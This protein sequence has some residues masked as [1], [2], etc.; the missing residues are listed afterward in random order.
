M[1]NQEWRDV[2]L[3]I[4]LALLA[5]PLM[6]LQGSAEIKLPQVID[7]HMVLQRGRAA[8]V[9]GTAV[10]GEQVTVTFRDQKKITIADP[11]GKWRVGLDALKAGGPDDLVIT[12]SKSKARTLEDV[13]VGDVW[14][15]SGQ[16]NMQ[17]GIAEAVHADPVLAALASNTYSRIRL[18]S[19]DTRGWNWQRKFTPP[20]PDKI[21]ETSAPG[22][23]VATSEALPHFSALL[24]SFGAVLQKEIDVPIG[25]I[26]GSLGATPSGAWVPR[27]AYAA[28]DKIK[29]AI[30]RYEKE[31]YP[32]IMA[33]ERRQ[34]Q[35]RCDEAKQAG[36]EPPPEPWQ[37][38]RLK[39]GAYVKHPKFS[40]AHV[41]YELRI[42]PIMPFAIRGVLWDQGESQVDFVGVDQ[43]TLMG[44][45]IAGWRKDWG[46]DFPFLYMQKPSGPGCAWDYA[47][48]VTCKAVPF[49]PL[50]ETVPPSRDGLF[51]E[52]FI[53]LM[54]YPDTHM[55]PCSDL[56]PGNHP[57]NKSGYGIR[58][59]RVA[60]SVAYGHKGTI[61]GPRFESYAIAGGNVRVA[62]SDVGEGLAWK[63]GEKLQGFALAGADEVFH[64]A[65][66]VID[67]NTVVV[68]CAEVKK[69]VAVRY[70][71]GATYEW[72]NLF[73]KDGLPA[74]PFRTDDW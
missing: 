19:T 5:L 36:R 59:A 16:S 66:A 6:P 57:L 72:A 46:Q 47:D 37:W 34:W 15:G 43:Y 74:I 71:W 42:K 30:A 39:P 61:Y 38:G 7:N 2:P 24:F 28:S 62:F 69:P 35:A 44:V 58:S 9:W 65:D 32:G 73:N 11:D 45:L 14:V 21:L 60:L 54:D 55:V 52:A 51:A 20:P 56:G 4:T 17:L 10:P 26:E 25:L 53:R 18:L 49:A 27:D 68:S 50:P 41:H 8:P 70:G 22:W 29:A 64:W 63:H 12:G 13:L 48:P 40:G 31:V 67:K 23:H 3:A 1:A 33:Q